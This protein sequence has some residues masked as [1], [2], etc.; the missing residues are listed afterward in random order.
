M[1]RDLQQLKWGAFWAGRLT[2]P[3]PEY[4]ECYV[5]PCELVSFPRKGHWCFAIA[6]KDKAGKLPDCW[7]SQHLQETTV[8]DD[9]PPKVLGFP[10]LLNRHHGLRAPA[11]A[12]FVLPAWRQTLF[13]LESV[14]DARIK[15]IGTGEQTFFAYNNVSLYIM[16]YVFSCPEADFPMPLQSG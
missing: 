7:S 8:L 14:T 3:R 6:M 1:T 15:L 4:L 5:A 2:G 10:E 16:V 9:V 12:Q 13:S 11:I